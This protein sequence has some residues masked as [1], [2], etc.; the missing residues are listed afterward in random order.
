VFSFNR[1]CASFGV[2]ADDRRRSMGRFLGELP[3][4]TGLAPKIRRFAPEFRSQL[5]DFG[6]RIR[7]QLFPFT[8]IAQRRFELRCQLPSMLAKGPDLFCQLLASLPGLRRQAN[9]ELACLGL[10]LEPERQL[11]DPLS[12]LVQLSRDSFACSLSPGRLVVGRH[13]FSPQN[14]DKHAR[15]TAA[16]L[17]FTPV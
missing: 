17:L 7:E 12:E 5:R 14:N 2:A 10:T 16:M 13:R 8:G 4:L 3:E 15:S 6:A 9:I 11:P 1:R